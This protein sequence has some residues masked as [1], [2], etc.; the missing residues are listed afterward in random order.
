MTSPASI[1][2]VDDTPTNLL[3]LGTILEK[4][5]FEVRVATN[6][7]E[8]L[9]HAGANPPP[10]LI[11]LDILMPR[12][13]GYEVCRRLK[14]DP[15][16]SPIPVI[17]VTALGMVADKLKGFRAGAV[18]FIT[19]PFD[20]EE[21]L[22]RVRTHLSLARMEELAA[23]I[24]ERKRSEKALL[25]SEALLKMSQRIGHMGSWKWHL[26]SGRLQWSDETYRIF[27]LSRATANDSLAE[28]IETSIHPGDRERVLAST[29]SSR[30]S[31]TPITEHYRVV[32]PDGSIHH[33]W[34]ESGELERAPDGSPLFLHGVVKDV[35][36]LRRAEDERQ[37]LEATQ[38][39][40]RKLEA[41]GLMAGGIAHDFNNMLGV[42]LGHAELARRRC[43][44][45]QPL[46]RDLEAILKAAHRT[47]ELTR[48]LLTFASRDA[49]RPVELPADQ[50][51]ESSLVPIRA[52]LPQG[53][54]LEWEPGAGPS[55]IRI[56][57]SQLE[58]ILSNLCSNAVEASPPDGEIRIS[59]LLESSAQD[60]ADP[61]NARQSQERLV[62]TI[63]DQGAGI[64]PEILEKIFDPFFTTKPRGK[65]IGL[66]LSTVLGAVR[67]NGGQIEIQSPP[68]GGTRIRILLPSCRSSHPDQPDKTALRK[69]PQ[70][71]ETILVV[72]DQPD[73]LEMTSMILQSQGFH[74]LKASSPWQ[75]LEI[76]RIHKE[77]IHLLLTDV[78][79]PG[80]NGRELVDQAQRE[81]PGLR[82]LYCSGYTADT[83]SGTGPITNRMDFIQKP[84][85]IQELN[86]KVREILD[87][88]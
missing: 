30:E 11:L 34:V 36:E 17:F 77:S 46:V 21:V 10:H 62:I 41:L 69:N 64:P 15:R 4:A 22:A 9:D 85:S 76:L 47:A 27:G 66:G 25:E 13:D 71:T 23:E 26:P 40:A 81:V 20:A 70:G 87:R 84:Y 58:Q 50:A 35:T 19:K 14:S 38:A 88:P 29:A 12:M 8:A 74:I 42:I 16:T 18:D 59:T 31:G 2:I 45:D 75:A 80:M 32:H 28:V 51:I 86:R 52:T 7:P 49:I 54:R 39:H 65:G 57:P 82:H 72:E 5:G 68:G 1:L 60:G 73:V 33:V 6:G 78:I 83:M 37:V 44:D 55:R 56:D 24:E 48:Q 43:H 67:Q 63:A 79:M 3:L 53:I 61:E